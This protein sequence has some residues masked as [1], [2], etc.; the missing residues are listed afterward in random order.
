MKKITIAIDGYSSYGKSTMAKQLAKELGYVFV[1][2]GAMYRAITLYLMHNNID[3]TNQQDLNI[4]LS[5]INLVFKW[6]AEKQISELYLNDECVADA[7]RTMEVASK[8]SVV[9]ALPDVR[10]FAVFQQQAMGKNKGIVM[11]GRDIG[12][13]VF[14]DAELKIFVT[15]DLEVRVQRRYLE[16]KAQDPNISLEEVKANLSARD[17]IDTTRKESPLKKADDAILL[18]NSN[19]TREEQLLLVLGWARQK[20]GLS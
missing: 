1:D 17:H 10:K 8:V 7:I 9:A 20:M 3:W 18:D 12:T 14:P 4:A 11:D 15:A 5:K 6:N 2:S 13:V 19:I 16:L